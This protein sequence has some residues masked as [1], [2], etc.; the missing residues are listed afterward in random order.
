ARFTDGVFAGSPGNAKP[1]APIQRAFV[2]FVQNA[3]P[4][5]KTSRLAIVQPLGA[6]VTASFDQF[7]P[8]PSIDVPITAHSTATRTV[9]VASATDPKASVTID[10]AEIAGGFPVPGGL[11]SSV[12]L[13]P[14]LSN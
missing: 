4:V 7:L 11:T 14:D 13:N 9:F 2:V 1:L 8:G 3:Q 6:G 10:V 5:P 12:V